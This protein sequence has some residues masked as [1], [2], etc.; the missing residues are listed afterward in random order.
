MPFLF[1][2]EGFAVGDQETEIAGAGLINPWK[3]NFVQYSV[4]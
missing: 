3:V 4:T 1:R 2:K